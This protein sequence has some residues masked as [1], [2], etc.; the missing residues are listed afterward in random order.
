MFLL[1][2]IRGCP[3]EDDYSGIVARYKSEVIVEAWH[4]YC[5]YYL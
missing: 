2:A 4:Y 5:Y 3:E 1:C